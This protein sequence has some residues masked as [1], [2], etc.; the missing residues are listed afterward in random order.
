MDCS[1]SGGVFGNTA[2]DA[3]GG[4]YGLY[5]SEVDSIICDWGTKKTSDNSPDDYT[6]DWSGLSETGWGS[7]T[8]VSERCY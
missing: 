2:T 1:T 3:G 6:C 7:S 4:A 5:T 8:T